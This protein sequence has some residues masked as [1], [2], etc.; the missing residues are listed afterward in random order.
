MKKFKFGISFLLLVFICLMLNKLLLLIN[1][2]LAL[3]LHELA[4]IYIATK[5]GYSLKEFKISLFGVN[6]TLNEQI[7]D[8]DSFAINMAGPV[9]NL[10]LTVVC[11]AMYWL[12]PKSFVVLNLFCV[13]N[14]TLAIFNLIP[15]YPLDGGKIFAS[16]LDNKKYKKLEKIIRYALSG[17][18][19]ICFVISCFYKTNWFFVIL[20]V[21]LITSKGEKPNKMSLFKYS[22][23]KK[24]EKVELLKTSGEESLF[25][26]LK[27]IQSKKYTIFYFNLNKPMYVDED[28]IIE[29]S[30]KYPLVTK[31]KEAC[32]F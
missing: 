23:N 11:V 5:K 13:S 30:T 27:K 28:E 29:L 26:L 3:I 10:I 18:T 16:S 8:S 22:K 32:K 25:E 12:V 6:V 1:Y 7:D 14:L 15:I 21:F 19:L 24:F 4:H 9:F 20:F 17:I 31:L 2:I